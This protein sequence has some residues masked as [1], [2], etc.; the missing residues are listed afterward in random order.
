MKGFIFFDYDGTLADE[1][2][3][4][5]F[6]TEKSVQSIRKLSDNGYIPILATGRSKLY[7]PIDSAPFGGFLTSNGTYCEID[8]RVL[9][10][11]RIESEL[12]DELTEEF[13]RVGIGYSLENTHGC[14][15]WG[16]ETTGFNKMIE[17]FRLPKEIFK[18]LADG[19]SFS[20]NKLIISFD[21]WDKYNAVKEKFSDKFVFSPHRS[22]MSAD[23]DRIGFSK[24]SGIKRL[25]RMTGVDASDVY[26]IGDG[27]NDYE[28]LEAAGHGIAMTPHYD[29]LLE[30]CEFVTD[31]VA[32]EGVTK[33]LVRLGLI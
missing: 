24:G 20:A 7:S 4:I 1:R 9:F 22:G 32:N 16:M 3:N 2:E 10:D 14:R 19:E 33:A 31:S 11:L 25:M 13:R 8:G 18:P 27:T 30:V 29:K 15:T 5:F 28:M 26:A 6:P 23:V 21:S 12:A 17:I